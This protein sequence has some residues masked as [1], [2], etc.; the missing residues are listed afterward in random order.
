MDS[1]PRG[2]EPPRT[3]REGNQN[4]RN[5]GGSEAST[6][7]NVTAGEDKDCHRNEGSVV[8]REITTSTKDNKTDAVG[9]LA[10]EGRAVGHGKRHN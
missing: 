8:G 6:K 7:N 10:R 1:P 3:T 4:P 9:A 2:W 5:N